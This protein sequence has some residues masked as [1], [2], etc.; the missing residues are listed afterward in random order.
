M[1]RRARDIEQLIEPTV[2]AMG[3]ELWGIDSNRNGA[4][5]KLC[6]YI[7]SD[8]GIAVD[9]CEAVSRQ[10][11][12][13]LDVDDSF[14]DSYTL[15]VSSPGL[16]RILFKDNH[17]QMNIGQLLDIRM[18]VPL[19]GRRRVEARLV[20]V[21]DSELT[22]TVDDDEYLIPLERVRRA[23]VVPQFD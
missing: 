9:D 12:S 7:D 23:R 21:E 2:G 1:N 8:S 5:E 11:S 15:E 20:G 13:L 17:F 6:V 4:H 10:L 22:V 18:E 16:D 19:D 14:N 3:F